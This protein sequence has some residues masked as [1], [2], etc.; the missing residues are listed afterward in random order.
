MFWKRSGIVV[1]C[2]V[3][4]S[5]VLFDGLSQQSARSDDGSAA[6]FK[7]K[8]VELKDKGEFTVLLQFAAGKKY[9][10]TTNGTKETDV[11]LF[12]YDPSEKEIGKDVSPGPKCDV[13]FT[14]TTAGKYKLLVKNSGGA[15]KVTLD[16]KPAP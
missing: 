6:D 16:V 5:A 4:V 10:A 8:T 11:H 13:S 1:L 3:C 14:T 2:V 7:G 12:V 15:N 9:A